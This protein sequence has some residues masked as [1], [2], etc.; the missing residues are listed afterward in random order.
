LFGGSLADHGRIAVK[1]WHAHGAEC[2]RRYL[3]SVF[4]VSVLH[5][6]SGMKILNIIMQTTAQKQT[7]K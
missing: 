3:L 4:I 6:A 1:D 7:K 5:D 2:E